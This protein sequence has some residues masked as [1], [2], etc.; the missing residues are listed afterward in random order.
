VTHATEI[1]AIRR[2]LGDVPVEDRITEAVASSSATNWTVATISLFQP[3][4][5]WEM[6]DVSSTGAEQIRI[7]TLPTDGTGLF[8]SGGIQRGVNGS[9]A[10]SSHA[11]ELAMYLDPRFKAD[12]I[13]QFIDK[14]LAVDLYENDVFEIVEHEITS[15]AATNE[16]N[17]PSSSCEEFLEVY[18]RINSNDERVYLDS[19]TRRLLNA[20]TDLYANGKSAV[21][22][23]NYG[24]PGTAIYYVNCKHRL[25]ITTLTARQSEALRAKVCS[26]LLTSKELSRLSG[27][28]N[29]GDRTVNVGDSTRIAAAYWEREA[30]RLIKQE[31]FELRQLIQPERRFIRKRRYRGI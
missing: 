18:Q 21:I 8:A 12:L 10:A 2:M 30:D 24:V 14:V 7:L 26:Y 9:T 31:A 11:D 23:Q 5:I 28:T 13:C 16:Y 25:S 27:P 4:Q 15:S 22:R 17:A 19:F 29:Q 3:N 6:A 20:D 1:V